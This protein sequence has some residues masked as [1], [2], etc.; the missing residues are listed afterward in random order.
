[1]SRK[2]IYS[3]KLFLSFEAIYLLRKKIAMFIKL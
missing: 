3:F 1:M 2:I